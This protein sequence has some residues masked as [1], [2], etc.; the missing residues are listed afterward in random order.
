MTRKIHLPAFLTLSTLF[1]L[2]TAATSVC[3]QDVGKAE[4]GTVYFYRTSEG[5]SIDGRKTKVKLNGKH[6]ISIGE[7]RFVGVKLPVGK[8]IIKQRK[9][10]SEMQVN[11]HNGGVYYVKISQTFGTLSVRQ[12]CV[13]VPAPVALFEMR[14]MKPLDEGNIKDKVFQIIKELPTAP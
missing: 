4:Y 11:V 8:H 10:N 12:D 2:L 7:Q 13:E 1:V 9:K 3:G 14:D 6:L 5:A